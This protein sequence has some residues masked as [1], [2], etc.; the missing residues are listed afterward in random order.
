[1]YCNST[2]GS[3]LHVTI[4]F[5]MASKLFHVLCFVAARLKFLLFAGV[6]SVVE[7]SQESSGRFILVIHTVYLIAGGFIP[8][9]LSVSCSF[10]VCLIVL[11][12]VR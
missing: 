4:Q 12:Y 7:S 3:K 10:V 8:G 11:W 6:S 2:D 5:K 9:S 1:M